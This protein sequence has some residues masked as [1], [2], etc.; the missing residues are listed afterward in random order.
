VAHHFIYVGSELLRG[1]AKTEDQ[2][3][4]VG[5]ADHAIGGL[6]YTVP[7]DGPDGRSGTLYAWLKTGTSQ[8][9]FD[10]QRQTWFPAA[11]NGELPQGRYWVGVWKDAPPT[12]M[13]LRRPYRY[14]GKSVE[15]AGQHWLVPVP[16]ELPH[17]ARLADDGSW[18]YVIQR[19][20]HDYYLR[21]LDYRSDAAEGGARL[22]LLN[23][24]TLSLEA[25]SL[26]YRL[27]PELASHLR[28]FDQNSA[29]R[30]FAAALD[31]DLR[32]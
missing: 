6:P 8:K 9:H 27:P 7:T 3:A 19:Q 17:D 25:L 1:I 16:H 21:V 31:L 20:Y 11:Q 30:A 4:S 13:D 12:E 10:P 26:N 15:L 18:R 28:L 29:A 32:E 23:M 22:T 14:G 24:L 5:L 2:L